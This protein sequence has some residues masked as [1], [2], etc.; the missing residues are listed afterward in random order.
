[1]YPGV[2][3]G[4]V[5][6]SLTGIFSLF[7]ASYARYGTV[8]YWVWLTVFVVCVLTAFWVEKAHFDRMDENNS[9]TT[10]PPEA[11]PTDS[12]PLG[13]KTT[14]LIFD[15][16]H[17]VYRQEIG[18]EEDVHRT[19][20]F[21]ATALGL[22]IASLNYSATQLPSWGVVLKSCR[23]GVSSSLSWHII[24]CA[25]LVLLADLSL[26]LV[27]CLSG[28]VLWYL[29]LATRTRDYTRVGPE[30]MIIE[31]TRTLHTNHASN[32]LKGDQLDA[33][34]VA[35]VR[36][37]LLDPFS[38]AISANR[39]VTLQRYHYR[40]RAVLCLLCS[41]LFALFVAMLALITTK[42]GVIGTSP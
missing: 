7:Q 33:A 11:R 28:A 24:P 29:F 40:A 25:W 19:L 37:Q 31:G 2:I 30:P 15:L 14:S 22:I 16:L 12:P 35:D 17:E 23:P 32:E 4:L 1:M 36:A 8:G 6:L 3:L 34:V 20:P 27:V 9:Q 13:E 10:P 38:T 21:F 5:C 18:A 26:F 41:L 39:E 42:F